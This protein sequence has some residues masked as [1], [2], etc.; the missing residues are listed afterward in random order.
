MAQREHLLSKYVILVFCFFTF[1]CSKSKDEKAITTFD[2]VD[3]LQIPNTTIL[4]VD[5][6]LKLQNGIYYY[7]GKSYSGFIKDVY[8]T[9]TLKSI[10]SYF[11]GK[12]HGITK[13]FFP[14][15]KLETERNYKNGIGYGRHFGYWQ[16]GNKKF[17]F[18]YFND[19][20]EG[21]QKQWYESGSKYCELSF[22][23]DQENGM[24]KAWRENGKPYINYEVKDGVRYGLQKSALCY[25]LKD[26][27]LK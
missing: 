20:R 2:K 13:T 6:S 23:N 9:D 15:G 7:G 21:L 8:E 18:M 27:K 5:T 3:V 4:K 17:D 19:K 22:T 12:Q 1:G 16:N 26:E 25:T 24:Q 11:E 10:S 14:N